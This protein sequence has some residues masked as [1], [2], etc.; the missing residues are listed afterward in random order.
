[1]CV[2][3]PLLLMSLMFAFVLMSSVIAMRVQ[4]IYFISKIH[5]FLLDS[6][7]ILSTCEDRMIDDFVMTFVITCMC[8]WRY[9]YIRVSV[10]I[11]VT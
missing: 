6:L 11:Y 4:N 8:L 1:M 10:F 7:L 2:M 9:V 3:S 5:C